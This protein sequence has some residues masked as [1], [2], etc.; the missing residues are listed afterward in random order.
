MINSHPSSIISPK[1]KIG[2]NVTIGPYCVINDDVKIGNN[3]KLKA[4]ITVY[5]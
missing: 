2:D 5:L 4:Q 3:V 1:A